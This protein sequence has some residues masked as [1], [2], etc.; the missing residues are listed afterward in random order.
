MVKY[1]QPQTKTRMTWHIPS[2]LNLSTYMYSLVGSMTISAV[3]PF[4]P[5]NPMYRTLTLF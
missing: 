2:P 3:Q 5:R 4:Y 1:K